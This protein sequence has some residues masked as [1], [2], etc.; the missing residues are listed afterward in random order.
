MANPWPN[1]KPNSLPPPPPPPDR[2]AQSSYS[3]APAFCP[4]FP[5]SH[6]EHADCCSASTPRLPAAFV[7]LCCEPP[8]T[9]CEPLIK[10]RRVGAWLSA[11]RGLEARLRDATTRR[12]KK[13]KNN[14]G[15]ASAVLAGPFPSSDLAAIRPIVT[16]WDACN[17]Q[18]TT[19]NYHQYADVVNCQS[20]GRKRLLLRRRL[21]PFRRLRECAILLRTT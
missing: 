11:T 10:N 5:A 6:V 2:H 17:P 18:H 9:C 3:T 19:S 1:S 7:Q 4:L 21:R 14:S 16:S 12:E 15:S 8:V 13:K 20:V